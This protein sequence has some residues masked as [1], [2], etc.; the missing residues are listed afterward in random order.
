MGP[1]YTFLYLFLLPKR[2]GLKGRGSMLKK[3][4]VILLI[5]SFLLCSCSTAD[6][7]SGSAL[8]ISG[9]IV[10]VTP[11]AGTPVPSP[12]L[13]PTRPAYNPGQLVD[14][15]AQTGDTL[16]ALAMHFNTSVKEI[17]AANTFIP[18]SATT[19]PP[20][21]PMKIPIYY[22]P[23][24]GNPFQI[25]PDSLFVNGP[26]QIGF[27]TQEFVDQHPGWLKNYVEYAVE[28]NRSGAN[29]VDYMAL[30]YSVSP[31]LILALLEYI[32]GALTTPEI[33]PA[34][35]T[36]SLGY[37]D[38][39]HHG[40]FMQLSWAV[41]TLNNGY[42]GWRQGD[43]KTLELLN[44]SIERPDPWQNAATDSLQYFFSKLLSPDSYARAISQDGI[45]KTY[46]DLFGDPWQSVQAHIPGSLQQPGLRF[47][48]AEKQTWAFTGG[49][50][51]G[52]GIG[53]PYAALD[54]A[55]PV[56]G[57]GCNTAD[58]AA[59]AMANGVITRSGLDGVTLDL[60]GDGDER[61]GWV[62]FYL[63][64]A[65]QGRIPAGALVKAGDPIG[66][67]SCEGG[68]ATGSH[69][70]IV[71][72]YNGEWIPAYGPLAFN[73]EGWIAN[74]GGQPYQGSM[75]R[76]SRTIIASQYSDGPSHIESQGRP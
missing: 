49:P 21:M 44:G 46:R 47:P 14:Y 10:T 54:F 37:T 6:Q 70:H 43:L 74:F 50:H 40:L 41:N 51:T 12:V 35:Q 13:F 63:H 26:G 30:N 61:T 34:A 42:Y 9:A 65:A 17:L 69:I 38:P 45:A 1:H 27:N 48:F 62:I 7:S 72:K 22:A 52:W 29:I 60:D 2:K 25:I 66:F 73:L 32:S 76:F 68:E 20:G 23:F 4:G 57:G 31:R 64:I 3:L 36:Y 18:A 56:P 5:G 58:E 28:D 53:E 8:P 19:L 67:P 15:V 71:R 59:I 16:P 39:N 75:T 11:D 24:W 33:P 55:P